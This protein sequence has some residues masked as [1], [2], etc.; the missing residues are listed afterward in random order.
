FAVAAAASV[1]AA[2]SGGSGAPTTEN[3]SNGGPPSS[4]YNGPPPAT[5][6]VQSFKLNLWDSIHMSNRCGACHSEE[7]GQAPLFA[8]SV[9]IN[10]AYAEANGVVTLTSPQDSMMVTK[11]ECGHNCWL[12]SDAACGDI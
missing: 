4:A 11:V 2:C 6:D 10:L 5:A 8:R 9:D 7:G 3:P 12:S 1:L